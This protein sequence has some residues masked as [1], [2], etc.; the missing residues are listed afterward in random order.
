MPFKKYFGDCKYFA[1]DLDKYFTEG[2]DKSVANVLTK[3][4]RNKN[5]SNF[6]GQRPKVLAC[7]KADGSMVTTQKLK[8]SHK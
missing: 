5:K 3:Y 2:N 6:L 8:A 1:D 4:S 7:N